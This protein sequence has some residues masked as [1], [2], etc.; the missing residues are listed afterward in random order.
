MISASDVGYKSCPLNMVLVAMFVFNLFNN[1]DL[2]ALPAALKP[3]QKDLGFQEV[4]M[5]SL[6]SYVFLGLV[7]GSALATVLFGNF[8]YKAIVSASL[9]G[10]AIGMCI[11]I[12]FKTYY[13]LGFARFVSGFCQIY[14]Q[15]YIPLVIDTFCSVK[16]KA[17]WLPLVV[18]SSPLG[19]CLGYTT[20]GLLI[21]YNFP[22]RVPFFLIACAMVASAIILWLIPNK[23]ININIIQGKKLKEIN[24]RKSE[25]HKI[26]LDFNIHIQ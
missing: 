3:I 16:Q 5:G 18:I 1:A 4:E 15:I 10:N 11:F 25:G 23:Y 17:I 6:G 2:G 7:L 26:D 8:S 13:A 22:W 12:Y 24:K 14:L 21:S 19:Q 9:I 20:S